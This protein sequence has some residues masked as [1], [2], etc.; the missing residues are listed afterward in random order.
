MAVLLVEMRFCSLDPALAKVIFDLKALLDRA[1]QGMRD[2]VLRL[3][4]GA[5]DMGLVP[6]IEWL[7]QEFS[8]RTELPCTLHVADESTSLDE[9]RSIVVFRIVQ[10]S[11]TN[12]TRYAGATRVDITICRMGNEWVIEICDNGKGFDTSQ[13]R[14]QKTFGLLGMRERAKAL[15]GRVDIES[16][17]LEGTTVRVTIPIELENAKES[18]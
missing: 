2:V 18:P 4:P 16:A 3:R 13:T 17:P 14:G 8:R 15:G 9:T 7:C 6:A 5:L 10:E 12:I 1:I 11:L